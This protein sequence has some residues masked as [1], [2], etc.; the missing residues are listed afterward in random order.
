M[1]A[2]DND[3]GA[4]LVVARRTIRERV[5]RGMTVHH[6]QGVVERYDVTNRRGQTPISGDGLVSTQ[7]TDVIIAAVNKLCGD[8]RVV[9]KT[10]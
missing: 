5:C 8:L 1:V 9:R 3:S 7:K 2:V 4:L 6:V 10:A